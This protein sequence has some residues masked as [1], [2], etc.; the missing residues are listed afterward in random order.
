V[1]F[2]HRAKS[3]PGTSE[4]IRKV[5]E[6]QLEF[7]RKSWIT[8][9][10][11]DRLG[12]VNLETG[13]LEK[14]LFS[15]KKMDHSALASVFS[16]TLK[17]AGIGQRDLEEWKSGFVQ[18]SDHILNLKCSPD[19]RMLFCATT[20]G[21]RV[22]DWDETVSAT[23]ATPRPLFAITP[24]TDTQPG[25][26]DD[27]YYSNFIYDVILD[28]ALNRLLFCGIEGV[29][30][31]LNLGDGSAGILLDPPGKGPIWRLQLSPNREFI[32]CFCGPPAEERDKKP[33][34]IQ[35]WNYSALCKVAGLS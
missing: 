12:I 10:R 32:C 11:D 27:R 28:E 20:V 18:G 7:I 13:K 3:E 29:I 16:G 17:Q 35:V 4:D 19:G 14:V 9:P 26:L 34:F 5:I 8:R 22:L 1:Y 2:R 33:W 30:R 24:R 6:R 31:F 25:V 23:E 21:L 15:G